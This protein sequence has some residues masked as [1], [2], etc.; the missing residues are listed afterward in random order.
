MS[1][2]INTKLSVKNFERYPSINTLSIS[3][4]EEKNM[5]P[6]EEWIYGTLNKVS[7]TRNINFKNQK[8]FNG[9]Q[10]KRIDLYKFYFLFNI[11]F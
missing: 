11:S 5:K 3:Q 8:A 6:V 1:K 4:N 7:S 2:K 9:Y 10:K